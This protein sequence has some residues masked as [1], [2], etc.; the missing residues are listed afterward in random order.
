F[1]VVDD[2]GRQIGAGDDLEALRTQL[3]KRVDASVSAQAD[4]L[5]RRDLPTFPAEGVPALREST[6][7]GLKLTGYPALVARRGADGRLE[8]VD[9]AVL[10]TADEQALAHR[11]GVIAL[12]D[13]EVGSDLSGVLNALPNPTKLAVAGSRYASTAALLADASCAATVHLAGNAQVRTREDFDQLSQRVR[14]QHD[15]L[16]AQAVK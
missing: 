3:K 4:D 5:A 2:K 12:L 13:R 11:E 14:T 8:R 1:R 10:A 6:V 9:L 7:G 16:A 15:A